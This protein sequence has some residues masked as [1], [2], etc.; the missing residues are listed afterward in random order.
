MCGV[1]GS[2]GHR[3][4]VLHLVVGRHGGLVRRDGGR[5]LGFADG[6]GGPAVGC[7]RVRAGE[8]GRHPPV[9]A[10]GPRNVSGRIERH[11]AK[12]ER[13]GFVARIVL[14]IDDVAHTN[15][16]AVGADGGDGR[17]C[18]AA[19]G[20]DGSAADK[21]AAGAKTGVAYG[22]VADTRC[23]CTRHVDQPQ[24]AA[25]ADG[26]LPIGGGDFGQLEGHLVVDVLADD[27]VAGLAAHG[28]RRLAAVGRGSDDEVGLVGLEGDVGGL[29][30][31]GAQEV[32]AGFGI[33]K[34]H[35]RSRAVAVGIGCSRRFDRGVVR[36]VD[37]VRAG[38]HAGPG[39]V[40]APAQGAIGAIDK[41]HAVT[42]VQG[43]KN[44]DLVACNVRYRPCSAN[45]DLHLGHRRTIALVKLQGGC[46]GGQVAVERVLH[47][48]IERPFGGGALVFHRNG[49]AHR[50]AA[51]EAAGVAGADVADG[52]AGERRT[53]H[54]GL[55]GDAGLRVVLVGVTLVH[56]HIGLAQHD[57]VDRGGGAGLVL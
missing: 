19:V 41:A 28:D 51:V 47:L 35:Q 30:P 9:G 1:A 20:A 2:I 12:L 23:R 49:D 55:A 5:E 13:N 32:A 21:G 31:G 53:R 14:A 15:G 36:E 54:K 26:D 38:G 11:G 39:V 10:S 8:S 22:D 6:D 25:Q 24:A 43:R 42:R 52:A 16:E 48:D 56:L 33:G 7:D 17:C 3:Q 37:D 57:L 44:G 18:R 27:G 29:R 46:V 45:L 40:L 50:V 34:T 4:R